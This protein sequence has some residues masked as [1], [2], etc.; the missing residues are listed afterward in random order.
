MHF[1]E[2]TEA[3]RTV[4]ELYRLLT[5]S[6]PAFAFLPVVHADRMRIMLERGHRYNGSSSSLRDQCFYMGDQSMFHRAYDPMN[7]CKQPIN[8]G[9][10][11]IPDPEIRD[12]IED[13][14]NYTD[15]WMCL[16][17]QRTLNGG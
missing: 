9:G 3:E 8:G 6:D 15:I 7:R 17:N 13:T 10:V 5:K 2:L 12:L 11:N 14:G 16:R 4:V 1:S